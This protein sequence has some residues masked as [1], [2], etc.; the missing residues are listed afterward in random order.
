MSPSYGTSSENKK[1][2]KIN[3]TSSLLVSNLFCQF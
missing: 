1:W 3:G 2:K